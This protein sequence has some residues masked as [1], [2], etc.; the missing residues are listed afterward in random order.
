MTVNRKRTLAILLTFLLI[1]T[2]VPSTAL[3]AGAWAPNTSYQAG[4][5]VT[6]GGSNYSCLQGHTSVNG[7][8]PPN[9]PALWKL[10]TGGSIDTQAPTAPTNLIA[11]GSTTTSIS[12]S[13]TASTDNVGVTGYDVYRGA[14]LAGTATGTTFTASGLTAA[15]SY[16]FTVKA[17]DAA[18]NVSTASAVVTGTTS[19]V[20]GDTQAPTTPTNLSVTA[21]TPTSISLSW[22]AST[23]NV[24]VTGYDVYN[25]TTLA[26]TATATT[27][28]ATG[29]TAGTAYT[30]TVK[31]K[32]AAGNASAESAAVTGTTSTVP[33]DIQAPTVPT[34]LSVT[35]T[36]SSSISLSWTASTDNVGVTGY[37]VYKGTTLAGTSTATTFT[38]A[39]LTAGTAY[40]FTVKAK[41]AAGNVSAASAAVTGTI[42][43]VPGDSQ[44]PTAP[45]NLSSSAVT[46]TSVALSWTASTD[47]VG[48]TGYTIYQGMTSVGTAT[49]TIFTVTG[50]TADTTYSFTVKAKDAAGNISAASSALSVKTAANS[51]GLTGTKI[52]TYYPEWAVYGRGFKV[53][54]MDPTKSNV[55]NYA[56]ADIC[57]NGRHGN[58]DPTGPN[59]STWACADEVG[60][61]NVPNGTIVQGD[62]WADTGMSYP[63]DTWETPIKGSFNQLVKLKQANPNVK[64]II[65]V[66]GWTWSNRFS[67]VAADPTTRSNFAKSAVSFIKK[68]QFDGVDLDWEYPVGGGLA[69]NSYR[70]ADKQNYVL[71]LQAVRAELDTAGAADGKHYY[72]TIASG[73]GPS[74]I[75]NNELAS[76]ASILD[77]INLMSYDFHGGWDTK[78]AQNAPLYY[79][80]ADTTADPINFNI[81]KAVTNYLAA[82]VPASKIVLGLAYYGRGWTGCA[83]VNGGQ[84]QPCTGVSQTGTWEKGSYDFYDLQ[85]NYINKN[86]YTRYWNAV[87]KTPYLYNPSGGTYISYDD[88]QSIQAKV[89]YIK[90]KGLGGAM[91]WEASGDRNKTLQNIVKQELLP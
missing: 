50:L 35:A 40:T 79:D 28:T 48:V 53:P 84:Y 31:A 61:I 45:T 52:V 85:A 29:L 60:N 17:K 41:D 68:Y 56:F 69:G 77:W 71:L 24:G 57:W 75:G 19:T 55:I 81:D 65:S 80:A 54:N 22:T 23:D 4:D 15:T 63:G 59:P 78:G 58:P 16:S 21:T 36:T 51:G 43:T 34:N 88:E 73:A 14:T 62:T 8:E 90:S 49:G 87:T 83:N 86:G 9:V 82:G 6:Y 74:F 33:G 3:G 67:D 66:G 91:A 76:L 47:N 20:P 7:W 64:T 37:D 5:I 46:M 89:D 72:L 12:L 2:L 11:T 42:P 1:F 27:F 10:Q 32:D 30:F 44:A 25:G 13:W 39:G 70:A 26:G 38:A 18:G